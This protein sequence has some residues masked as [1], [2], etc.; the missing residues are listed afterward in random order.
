MNPAEASATDVVISLH[1]ISPPRVGA[2]LLAARKQRSLTRRRV[3]RRIGAHASDVRDSE[4]GHAP[5]PHSLLES[6]HA[7]YGK[8]LTEQF[9]TRAPIELDGHRLVVATEEVVL[10]S[11]DTDEVL[12]AYL[13]MVA[14][15]RHAKRGEPIALRADDLVSLSTVLGMTREQVEARIEELCDSAERRARFLYVA[16]PRRNGGLPVVGLFAGLAVVAGVGCSGSST[17]AP[18]AA[19][20]PVEAT[21]TVPAAVP[22]NTMPP[23]IPSS[24]IA[25]GVTA[26][27]ADA[28]TTPTPTPTTLLAIGSAMSAQSSSTTVAQAAENA[29]PVI[30]PDTTPVS[31]LPYGPITIIQK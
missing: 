8:D 21:T 16:R 6:L 26:Q 13:D 25:H 14:R 30:T 15:L 23:S 11:N 28:P 3:A 20:P 24:T 22:D 5:V 17:S 2:L 18:P 12:N 1:D 7:C 19:R 29:R 31:I 27:A 10:Q 4:R 9:A